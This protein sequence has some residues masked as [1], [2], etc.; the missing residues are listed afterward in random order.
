MPEAASVFAAVPRWMPSTLAAMLLRLR[1]AEVSV[2]VPMAA[3]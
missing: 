3:I 1:L 2:E